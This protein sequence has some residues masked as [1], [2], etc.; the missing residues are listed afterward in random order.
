[1]CNHVG[2]DLKMLL[3]QYGRTYGSGCAK[4]EKKRAHND[5]SVTEHSIKPTESSDLDLFLQ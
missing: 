5:N 1:M 3:N 4:F 2:F